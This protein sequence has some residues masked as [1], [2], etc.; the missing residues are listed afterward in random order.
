PAR[1]GAVAA[2]LSAA[3]SA[4]TV[5]AARPARADVLARLAD[6]LAS[7]GRWSDAARIEE[8]R[9]ALVPESD[10]AWAALGG[11]D[12]EVAQR[13]PEAERAAAFE[14]AALALQEGLRRGPL[15]WLNLRNLSSLE[16]VWAALDRD[17]R[18]AHLA[19]ADRYFAE[20][21]RRAP[22]FARLWSE[23]GNVDAERG[24]FHS[25]FEKLERAISLRGEFDATI[26]AN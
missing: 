16:R 14:H 18:A 6:E 5:S 10:L 2:A 8:E 19:S 15:N 7:A 1:D 4:L 22:A 24:D 23:W 11:A 9:V 17:G 26:V 12:L 25:A 3:A 21:S 20:A 13:V